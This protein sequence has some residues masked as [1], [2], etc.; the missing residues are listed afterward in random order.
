MNN[1]TVR[2]S[3]E[4]IEKQYGFMRLIKE[5]N[6]KLFGDKAPKAYVLTFG[7]QQ[8][9][10]DSER[11]AGMTEQMGYAVV[12]EPEDADLIVINTCAVR[13]HAELRAL[14]IT[15]QF[16]HLKAKNHALKIGICGCMVTQ[17]HRKED[18]KHKYPYVDFLFGTNML[19]RFPEILFESYRQKKR[20]FYFDHEASNIS[21]GLPVKRVH[22]FKAFVSVMYGCNNFCSYCV[23]PYVRGRE[24]SRRP[25]DIINE[26][27]DLAEQGYSEFTLLGQNV[28]SYGKDLDIEYDFSDLLTDICEIE[29]EFWVRFMTS[30]PK[31]ASK[32]LI[33]TMA[34]ESKIAKHL[35]LPFQSGDN[36]I[37]SV[38]NRRYTKESYLELIAYA[39]EKMPSIGLT[40]DVIVG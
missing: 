18:I 7:C 11:I 30:H 15:G 20:L 33:D 17:D 27:R 2:I 24:R 4:D 3:K 12:N 21:E 31:D 23:V 10:A 36:R 8:N 25:E 28:N 26:I 5:Q 14:S 22:N 32:K 6:E 39:K 13:E 37:L 35:H 1:N 29:G 38:M 9:E 40:S 19:Y 16:K 34:R